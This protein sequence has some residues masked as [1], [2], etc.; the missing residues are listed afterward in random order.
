MAPGSLA[1]ALKLYFPS[2]EAVLA[3][4]RAQTETQAHRRRRARRVT[5]AAASLLVLGWVAWQ[6][7]VWQSETLTTTVGQQSRHVLGDGS[8]VTLNTDSRLTVER[9]LLSRRLVLHRGEAA[10]TVTDGWRPFI[11]TSGGIA[12]RDIG[13]VFAVRRLDD[14]SQVTVLQGIVEVSFSRARSKATSPAI[15]LTEGRRL[16]TRD[17]ARTDTAGPTPA[18]S[19][20][21]FPV[22]TV[23]VAAAGAWQQGRLVFDGT[24][25]RDAVAEIQ[26]YLPESIILADAETGDL[27]LSGVHDIQGIRALLDS[28]P[29]ALPVR[30]EP[31]ADGGV[32]IRRIDRRR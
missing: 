30:L 7:P 4:A 18:A 29:K 19:D 6:D 32:L 5:G 13:T 21:A 16:R 8:R 3:E 24:P 2:R 11:V 22:E 12:V 25:L 10:F 14:G 27:R 26:R 23:N 15:L 17:E 20:T 28:L 9:R 31:R 1:D